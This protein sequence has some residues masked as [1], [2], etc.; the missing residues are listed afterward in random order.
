MADERRVLLVGASRGLGLGLAR[1]FAAQGWSVTATAR[2]PAAA[3]E[4]VP[5]VRVERVD[6]VEAAQVEALR[7]RLGGARFEVI[8]IV[9]GISNGA[10]ALV[11]TVPAEVASRI[12]LTNAY[13][14]LVFAERFHDLLAPGGMMAFMTSILGSVGGNSNGGWEVYRASKAA[15]N[16]LGRSYALRHGQDGS[17]VVLMHPGWVRTDMGGPNATLDV[18]TSTE[19]MVRVIT[20]QMGAG[21]CSYLD[22]TGATVPW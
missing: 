15:L 17:T 5:G 1:V 2:G 18:E 14:P 3:L 8:F 10:Q 22:Y 7:S 19:G 21:G 20:A 11:H 4:S 16:T 12:F 6:I 9:A 13:A